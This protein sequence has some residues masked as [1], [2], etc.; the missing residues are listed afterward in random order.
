MTCEI[1]FDPNDGDI[2]ELVSSK[3]VKGRKDYKCCECHDVILKGIKHESAGGLVCKEFC[4]YRTCLA[5]CEI[6]NEY[7]RNGLYYGGLWEAMNEVCQEMPLDSL[8]D[9]SPEAQQKL[10]I[11]L[12]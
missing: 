7:A 1:D 2:I 11:M 12:D 6:R 4:N 5:C 3:I 8:D 10:L 9:F